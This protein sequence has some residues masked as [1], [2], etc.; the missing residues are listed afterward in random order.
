MTAYTDQETTWI[1]QKIPFLANFR[2]FRMAFYELSIQKNV[3]DMCKLSKGPYMWAI[4][5]VSSQ[6]SLET[7]YIHFGG[8][9]THTFHQ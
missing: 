8:T 6:S 1:Q 3:Q 2:Y 5:G 9:K 7:E 4:K